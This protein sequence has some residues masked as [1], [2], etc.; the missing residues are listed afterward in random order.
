[1]KFVDEASLH[2]TAGDG[3][4][5]CVSFRR[6]AHVPRGGPN[7]GDGGKGGDVVIVGRKNLISLLDFK[8]KRNYK[9]EN[10]RPGGSANKTGRNG[11]D[12]TV[13][14]PLGTEI[15]DETN[16]LLLADIVS[17]GQTYVAA[18]GGRGGRGN[19]R[20]VTP[21]HR[22]PTEFDEGEPGEGRQLRLELKLLAGIGLIGLPNAGKSTLLSRLTAATPEVGDYPF[23]TLTPSL[24]V[25][26]EDSRHPGSL[27]GSGLVLAD[28]PGIIEGASQGKGLGL[29]FLRHIERTRMLVWVMD[30]SL[31]ELEQDYSTLKGELRE[32]REELSERTHL[33]VLNK[34]DLVTKK[35]AAA[36]GK[37]LRKKGEEVIFV[38][39]SAGTGLEELKTRLLE[40]AGEVGKG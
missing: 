11:A 38:S 17:E 39:A 36:K 13:S 14:V 24:G 23:T 20:F 19:L 28:I 1:M 40:M 25:M 37:L 22:T 32:Y 2:V 31:P 26:I 10:G 18:R 7:G 9:A 30:V 29:R 27:V 16:G 33:V 3:G 6:E 15:R 8:Y 35:E 21:V 5:G 12:V 34:I 4:R